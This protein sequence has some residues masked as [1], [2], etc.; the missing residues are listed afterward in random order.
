MFR[1]LRKRI[2]QQVG[3]RFARTYRLLWLLQVLFA[4]RLDPR[5][6][7]NY[8]SMMK[9][10]AW[11]RTMVSLFSNLQKLSIRLHTCSSRRVLPKIKPFAMEQHPRFFS[12]L[13]GS[14]THGIWLSKASILQRLLVVIAWLKRFARNNWIR[15]PLKHQKTRSSLQP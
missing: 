1:S 11:S 12:L 6:S 13:S 3:M 7:T 15:S 2:V 14:R 10:E 8:S 9:D 4:Q 5:V